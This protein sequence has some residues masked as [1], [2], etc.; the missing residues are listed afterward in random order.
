MDLFERQSDDIDQYII[1]D[2]N[3]NNRLLNAVSRRSSQ[4][5]KL[6]VCVCVGGGGLNRLRNVCSLLKNCE[7]LNGYS[8]NTVTKKKTGLLIPFISD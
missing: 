2:L 8:M 7:S 3:N 4:R 1:F 5:L 6:G